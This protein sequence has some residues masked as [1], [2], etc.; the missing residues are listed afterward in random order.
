MTE[1]CDSGYMS[2]DDYVWKKG[3]MREQ[4]VNTSSSEERS[5]LPRKRT[6]ERSSFV[7]RMSSLK[8]GLERKE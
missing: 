1:A 2:M 5:R 6:A 4:D 3:I 8:V 7:R